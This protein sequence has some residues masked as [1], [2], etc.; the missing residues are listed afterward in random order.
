M[1]Y[2]AEVDG[3]R[4]LAVLPVMLFHAGF[5][6]LSGG[7][8]GVDI[9]FVISGYLITSI[10]YRE[11]EADN[12]SFVNFYERR[13]R[14]ILPALY[15]VLIVCLPM[16][17]LFLI[18]QDF[19]EFSE[20][21]IG[22]IVFAS[23]I[24]F[25]SQTDYF[26]PS[27][28]Y[29]PLLH[30]WS[31][32]VEEQ[33]YIFFP[34]LLLFIYR[35]FPKG[36]FWLLSTLFVM[37]IALSHWGALY[38]PSAAYFLLPT[39]LWEL[40]MGSLIALSLRYHLFELTSNNKRIHSLLSAF[41]LFLII[42]SL[43]LI[44]GDTPFPSLWT[45]IPTGGAALIIIFTH[46]GTLIHRIL[47]GKLLVA[48]GLVSYSAYLW[49]QPVYAF[50]RHQYIVEQSAVGMAVA[51]ILSFILA[52]F[53]WR[54]VE[55]PFRN[56]EKISRRKL[57]LT[58]ILGSLFLLT[59]GW[60]GI[61]NNGFEDRFQISQE[62]SN[63]KFDLPRTDNGWCFYSVDTDTNL[64]VGEGGYT[65]KIG[66]KD[67]SYKGV[68][69]GD[70]Y[71]GMYEPFWDKIG[72]ESAMGLTSI[73]TN[74]CY[75]SFTDSFW[76]PNET[77]AYDQCLLNRKYVKDT[78]VDNDFIIL[79][80]VWGSLPK[81]NFNEV[82]DFIRSLSEHGTLKIIIMSQPPALT[83]S[84]VMRAVYTQGGRLEYATNETHVSKVNQTL[85]NLASESD[86]LLF[87][88]RSMLFKHSSSTGEIYTKQ[89]LPYS[90]DG[91]HISIFGSQEA[92][93]NFITNG[94]IETL[95]KFIR[96]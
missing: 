1:K 53:S 78:L 63:K 28:E 13:A 26:S 38:K 18:P 80:A 58:S 57:L 72:S 43:F 61:K 81:T 52:V 29:I 41:G 92:A 64:N 44:D 69:F 22:V 79:S 14:R 6:T 33:Y 35:R 76:W 9:F 36:V 34:M 4:A 91:G 17:W 86:S 71:A 70:S 90:L 23:N 49:H 46:E 10:I 40:L 47:S 45:L 54:Y 55:S 65:C 27:S 87:I 30:T 77:R 56:K 50:F 7:F 3:L 31:L 60:L 42:F 24:V 37:S 5:T 15:F 95:K 83:R 8:V 96:S 20:S 2:R 32:A 19:V 89:A 51:F 21:L 93:D 66:A 88:E 12:F 39:R 75:P 62:I 59:M 48:I 25:W 74:W 67:A 68:L 11:I 84:S 94:T 82:I 16:S 73:T 85:R